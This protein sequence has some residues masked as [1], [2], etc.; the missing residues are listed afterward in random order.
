MLL[1]LADVDVEGRALGINDDGDVVGYAIA[2]G[3]QSRPVVWYLDNGVY[4]RID[5]ST[6]GNGGR[7]KASD[8][9]S[10]GHIVGESG[11]STADR[12][13]TLWISGVAYNLDPGGTMSWATRINDCNWII[14]WRADSNYDFQAA[15]WIV[16][17][18]ACGGGAEPPTPDEQFAVLNSDV[19]ALIDA[20][21]LNAGQG[22]S[23][24]RKLDAAQKKY[25]K[26][27]IQTAVDIL[28][29]FIGQIEDLAA[30]GVLAQAEAQPLIE[31]AQALIDDL[32]A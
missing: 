21:S 16:G 11:S 18:Q 15:V 20:G 13:A 3:A 5:L 8:I 1:G 32:L 17:E 24:T 19:A 27:Q 2:P 14:G 28:A 6:L 12:F 25:D 7:G 31:G 23:L 26:G 29:D 10:A 22:N 30:E 4:G 9:N